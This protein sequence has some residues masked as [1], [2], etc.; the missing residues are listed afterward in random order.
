MQ[1]S[2]GRGQ[3][4]VLHCGQ[5]ELRRAGS[6]S[7]AQ[8]QLLGSTG[9]PETPGARGEAGTTSAGKEFLEPWQEHLLMVI[10]KLPEPLVGESP[11]EGGLV[12]KAQRQ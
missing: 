6:A 9:R 10:W 7:E 11:T 2:P 3:P 5:T 4:L 1:E 8:G 12:C